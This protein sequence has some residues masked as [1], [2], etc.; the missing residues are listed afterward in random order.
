MVQV[1]VPLW[2]GTTWDL[3][4]TA[5]NG[6]PEDRTEDF[7]LVQQEQHPE[8]VEINSNIAEIERSYPHYTYLFIRNIA[9]SGH[10]FD[11]YYFVR[12]VVIKGGTIGIGDFADA[13]VQ[14]E[15][16]WCSW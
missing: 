3:S 16:G 13:Q 15:F 7:I 11:A 9:D 4:F 10:G 1:E 14:P 6:V 5:Q 12:F 8:R 2:M